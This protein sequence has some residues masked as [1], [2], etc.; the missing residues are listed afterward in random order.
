MA[1]MKSSAR[2][3][4][5]GTLYKFVLPDGSRVPDPASRYQPSD[6]H[7]PSEVVDS[8]FPW[9]DGAWLGRPWEET[10]IYE[11]HVGSFTA[12]GTFAA[13]TERLDYLF[14]LGVTA[15]EVMPVADFPGRWN[16]GYDG[17]LLFA[18][19]STY[20]RPE[21]FK[22]FVDAAHAKGIQVF[23][24]VVYNHFGPD[25]NYLEA[26]S[27]I[28][29]DRHKTP[30]GAAVNY[31]APGSEQVRK[32]VVENAIYWVD[33]FHLDGLRLDAVHAIKDDSRDSCS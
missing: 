15:I 9:T 31:D 17:V 24:D 28:F 30:W 4:R 10:V 3:P 27:P 5:P 12:D 22:A 25:G 1:G 20:G 19:D 33:E 16:W 13:A 11:L 21:D 2:M 32:F 6:V 8:A 18:P 7:G 29:T 26:Y 23:L 14:D